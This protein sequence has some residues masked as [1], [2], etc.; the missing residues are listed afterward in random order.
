MTVD[1]ALA[2]YLQQNNLGPSLLRRVAAGIYFLGKIKLAIKLT[3]PSSSSSSSSR[4]INQQ[5]CCMPL[6]LTHEEKVQQQQRFVPLHAFLKQ[7]GV[8]DRSSSS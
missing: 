7:Q 1:R 4:S 2:L 3:R 8:F 5:L 6:H